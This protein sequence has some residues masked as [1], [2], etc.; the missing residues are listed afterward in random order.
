MYSLSNL[1]RGDFATISR[2]SPHTTEVN[3]LY[4]WY[5]ATTLLK[6]LPIRYLHWHQRLPRHQ[7]RRHPSSS[8]SF[9]TRDSPVPSRTRCPSSTSCCWTRRSSSCPSRCPRPAPTPSPGRSGPL[10][11]PAPAPPSAARGATSCSAWVA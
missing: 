8:F 4:D 5:F 2:W 11:P 10:S 9:S 6:Q 7:H 1:D 3:L